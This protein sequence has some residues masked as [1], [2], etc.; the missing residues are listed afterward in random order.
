MTLSMDKALVYAYATITLLASAFAGYLGPLVTEQG[1][2]LY[3]YA[4]IEMAK[5]P[6]RNPDFNWLTSLTILTVIWVTISALFF[7]M[8]VRVIRHVAY[9]VSVI[10]IASFVF[11]LSSK[12][13]SSWLVTFSIVMAVPNALLA[14]ATLLLGH[15]RIVPWS[16]MLTTVGCIIMTIV[17]Y[18]YYF[19]TI[20]IT[21][22]LG[23][24]TIIMPAI[25][26]VYS[27]GIEDNN[28]NYPEITSLL[29]VICT[30]LTPLSLIL[31]PLYAIDREKFREYHND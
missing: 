5:R 3:D 23:M 8:I 7:G 1:I 20:L 27:R 21:V 19:D 14:L 26:V 17:T 30:F 10:I 4:V 29:I 16:F 28:G 12:I 24:N 18:F 2:P 13:N 31:M 11:H 22:L 25:Y 15:S 6:W 9:G